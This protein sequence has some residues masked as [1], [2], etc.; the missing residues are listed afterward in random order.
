MEHFSPLGAIGERETGCIMEAPDTGLNQRAGVR[1]WVAA[2]DG[3][4][5]PSDEAG[6]GFPSAA[7]QEAQLAVRVL[8][9]LG[10]PSVQRRRR[11]PGY[12]DHLCAPVPPRGD[13]LRAEQRAGGR[14]R[15]RHRCGLAG[16]RVGVLDRQSLELA[17]K[18]LVLVDYEA[19]K[20]RQ[21][22]PI[23]V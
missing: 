9:E 21:D 22:V 3:I 14:R 2:V 12:Q 16:C 19:S 5:R 4:P 18:S 23:A 17:R 13:V 15:A 20:L 11:S 7:D 6:L 10:V 8:P 1:R